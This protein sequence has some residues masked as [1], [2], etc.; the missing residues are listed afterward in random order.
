[1][2]HA[3]IKSALAVFALAAAPAFAAP[4]DDAPV[5]VKTDH[6]TRLVAQKVKQYAALGKPELRRYLWS[7]YHIHRVW[8]DDVGVY[9][10]HLVSAEAEP[11]TTVVKAADDVR[12]VQSEGTVVA[13]K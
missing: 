2:K 4:P 9:S 13:A 5:A 11:A 10:G 3:T 1:M 7:T 6:L 12:V 8:L